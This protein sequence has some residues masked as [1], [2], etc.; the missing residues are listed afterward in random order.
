MS[1]YSASVPA[2]GTVKPEIRSFFENFYAISDTPDGHERYADQFTNDGVLIMASNKVQGRD[3]IIKMRHGMWEKVAKRSHKPAQLYAFGSGS[4][5]I[6]LYGTVDYTL[7]DGRGTT[8][9]WSARAHFSQV[10][11]ELKMDFYQVYLDTA[12]MANAK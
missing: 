12:A 8:V 6:M 4:D 3:S 1:Q 10:G 2:D 11:G 5:D 7:K 9:D